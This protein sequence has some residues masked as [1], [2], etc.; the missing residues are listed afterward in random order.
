VKNENAL[1]PLEPAAGGELSKADRNAA[2][3]KFHYAMQTVGQA[4]P[5]VLSHW[6]SICDGPGKNQ[7]K[8]TMRSAFLSTMSFDNKYFQDHL[9]TS[10]G[11]L[12]C[13]PTTDTL[14]CYTTHDEP[15]ELS[16]EP[17]ERS[18]D[19]RERSDE[20]K[21][22]PTAIEELWSIHNTAHPS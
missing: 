17:R 2:N 19:A 5:W 18:D 1:V 11:H 14:T 3:N 6:K 10:Q 7:K 15:R 21:V 20:P 13:A 12:G 22:R 8:A 16:D 4:H 9:D